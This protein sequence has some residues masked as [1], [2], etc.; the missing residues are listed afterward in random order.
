MYVTSTSL[1]YIF[2]G[3]FLIALAF[4]LYFKSLVVKTNSQSSSRKRIVGNMHN[5]EE[6]RHKNSNMSNL[7]GFWGVLSLILFIYLKFFY[8]AGLINMSYLIIY[9][10]IE[11][12]SVI[13][14]GIR[15]KS[16]QEQK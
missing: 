15:R 1:S 5:P 11:V 9:L 10:A 3:M 16:P 6:W 14:F 7:A 12:I 4:F 13:F 2:L 8:A